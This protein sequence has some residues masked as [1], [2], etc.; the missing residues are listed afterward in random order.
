M[1]RRLCDREVTAALKVS[2]RLFDRESTVALKWSALQER[3]MTEI[4]SLIER[5]DCALG[6]GSGR[7]HSKNPTTADTL[8]PSSML[9]L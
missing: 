7:L 9:N 3:G 4:G 6:Q 5:L 2:G 1:S 8:R